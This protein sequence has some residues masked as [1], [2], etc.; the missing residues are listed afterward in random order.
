M[1]IENKDREMSIGMYATVCLM[2][3]LFHCRLTIHTPIALL[4]PII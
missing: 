2:K 3:K 4:F 1:Q